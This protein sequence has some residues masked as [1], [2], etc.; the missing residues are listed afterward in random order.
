MEKIVRVINKKSRFEFFLFDKYTAGILL[1]GTEIKSIRA[2]KVSLGESYCSFDNGELFVKNMN[3]AEYSH[4]NIHNHEPKRQRKLLLNKK[5]LR[6]LLIKVKEKGFTVVV[7]QLFIN[8]RG[9]A[10]IEIALARG[11]KTYDK[12]ETIRE[13]D[14][15][16]ETGRLRNVRK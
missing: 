11:K 16:R 10:K 13:R 2:G 6:K 3:I 1:K 14:S 8:K 4:G 7:T 12:R 9:L 5:E 15:S